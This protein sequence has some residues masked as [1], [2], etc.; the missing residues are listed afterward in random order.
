[1]AGIRANYAL[2]IKYIQFPGYPETQLYYSLDV[3]PDKI[4]QKIDTL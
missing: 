4:M 3:L 2:V 1:M